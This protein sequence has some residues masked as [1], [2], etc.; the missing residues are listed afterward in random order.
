[1]PHLIAFAGR[2][3]SG[4]NTASNFIIAAYLKELGVVHEATCLNANG[5]ICVSD[6]YGDVEKAGVLNVNYNIDMIR[7][8]TGINILSFA[9]RL[10]KNICIDL[11]GLRP[12]QCYGTN[13]QKNSPTQL[14]WENMPTVF[15][16][17]INKTKKWGTL[18]NGSKVTFHNKDMIF[19]EPGPMS[20]RE[21]MQ[22]VGSDIFRAMFADVWTNATINDVKSSQGTWL[23]I[24]TDCRFPNE[25][26]AIQNAGGKVVRLRRGEHYP[27]KHKSE[28]ALNMFPLEDYDAVID[29]KHMKIEEQNKEIYKL[30]KGWNMMS[31]PYFDKM[32]SVEE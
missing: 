12:T 2:Q 18:K 14:M 11:F 9:D 20:A 22:Y 24:I 4:K 3:Q 16:R 30:L 19:H 1:M 31:I 5:E 26:K 28:T 15:Y 17:E 21:V 13:V 27:D 7:E 32:L 23:S 10:K 29:N 25:V 8:T 6:I